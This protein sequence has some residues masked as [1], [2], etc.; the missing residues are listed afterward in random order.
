MR[1]PRVAE[2]TRVMAVG[3]VM[4]DVLAVGI[5]HVADP[6]HV[7]YTPNEIETHIGGHPI[8]V[9]IDLAEMGRPA[10]WI[11]LVAAIGEGIYGSYATEIIDRYGFETYLQRVPSHDTGRNLVL[12]VAGEDRRF[13]IDPGANWYLDPDHVADAVSRFAPQVLTIR[14]GYSGIDLHLPELLE[15]MED[16]LVLLDIM[17]PHP[18]RPVDLVHPALRHVDLVHCNEREALLATG[19]P[20]LEAAIEHFLEQGVQSVFVTHG[21]SGAGA[22]TP[23]HSV[24]QQAFLVEAVDATG[25]GDAFCAGL[26]D[27]LI[28]L[29]SPPNRDTL[30]HIT[31]DDLTEML[32]RAQAMG[33]AASTRPGC[34]AGVTKVNVDAIR[35]DQGEAAIEST[36]ISRR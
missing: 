13:H 36:E 29:E 4:V 9:A 12:E 10:R 22:Y 2:P 5:P 19:A 27:F 18:D 30:E 33:A 20:N 3:T 31:S 1:G 23:S 34:V 32:E 24:R 17:Q 7:V 21:P 6:G 26:I 14:P 35:A 28:E 15:P 8:D 25:A 11:A 16:T